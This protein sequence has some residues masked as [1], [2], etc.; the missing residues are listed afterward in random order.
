MK[1]INWF[2]TVLTDR[3]CETSGGSRTAEKDLKSRA[4]CEEGGVNEKKRETRPFARLKRQCHC[5]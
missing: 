1:N 2:V 5:F 4:D 3:P